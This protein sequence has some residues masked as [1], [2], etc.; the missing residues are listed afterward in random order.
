MML[1]MLVSLELGA[2]L[3]WRS[4]HKV[5]WTQRGG[6]FHVFYPNVGIC[7]EEAN[8]PDETHRDILVLGGSVVDEMRDG[9]TRLERRLGD[10]IRLH[11]AGRIAHTTLDSRRKHE[12]LEDLGYDDVLVYHGI[13]DCKYDNMPA[14]LFDDGYSVYPFYQAVTALLRHPEADWFALPYT[15]E[16][17]WIQ[18]RHLK[19]V[20]WTKPTASAREEWWI[21]GSDV[22]S[23]RTFRSNLEDLVERS[24]R[25]GQ[26]VHLA[27]FA[28]YIPPDYTDEK[29]LAG[30]LDYDSP[31]LPAAIWGD[32]VNVRNCIAVHNEILRDIGSRYDNVR[33]IEVENAIPSEGRL[34]DDP[35][36]F[37]AAGKA[38]FFD[39]LEA[40]LRR[41]PS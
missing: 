16:F 37:S 4:E 13:N 1:L 7:R 22:K 41:P 20:K 12:W 39:A 18:A 28:S 40:G 33:I 5:P 35:C 25:L 6:I 14:E 36:H 26:T 29:F 11:V 24:R 10:D 32:A 8:R 27:T 34:Y 30:E 38:V 15:L 23:A 17:A 2:R 9:F 21:H 19:R 31:R 3:Y